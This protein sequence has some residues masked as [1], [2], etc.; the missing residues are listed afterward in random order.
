MDNL[1]KMGEFLETLNHPRLNLE[2][3]YNLNRLIISNEIES[4]IKKKKIPPKEVLHQTVSQG[5]S[6]THFKKN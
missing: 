4:V 3:I 2:E 5:N 6:N 1:G